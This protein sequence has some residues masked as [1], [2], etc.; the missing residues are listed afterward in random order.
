MEFSEGIS[1]GGKPSVGNSPKGKHPQTSSSYNGAGRHYV[2]K[3]RIIKEKEAGQRFLCG[4]PSGVDVILFP[5]SCDN[6]EKPNTKYSGK[7]R[8]YFHIFLFKF[9][10]VSLFFLLQKFDYFDTFCTKFCCLKILQ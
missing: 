1:P 5:L 9:F 4:F 7:L 3:P 8:L 10:S 6:E 2:G